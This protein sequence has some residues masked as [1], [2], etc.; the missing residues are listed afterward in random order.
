MRLADYLPVEQIAPHLEGKTKF[1]VIEELLDLIDQNGKLVD[2]EIALQDVLAREGYLSTG[3][4]NGLAIP[5]AKTDGVN[6]L[7]ISFGLKPEGVDF[8]SLDGK[9]AKLIFLVLSPRDTSGPHIQTLAIIS[10]NLKNAEMRESLLN[11]NSAEQIYQ[12]IS[13]QFK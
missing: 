11:A 3:L 13:D 5:H 7:V 1:E 8:E 6:E 10:R 12:I 4:E 2:R 9:P